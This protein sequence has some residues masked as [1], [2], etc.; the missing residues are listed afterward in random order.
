MPA[1]AP[2]LLSLALVAA[3]GPTASALGPAAAVSRRSAVCGALSSALIASRPLP[4]PAAPPGREGILMPP[5]SPIPG[6]GAGAPLRPVV[7]EAAAGEGA[8]WPPP[9]ATR[10]G[11]ERLGAA[12]LSPLSAALSPLAETELYYPAWLEGEWDVRA[13]LLRKVYPYGT[14]YVPSS[15]L[16]EGSPRNRSEGAGNVVSSRSRYVM[17]A[18]GAKGGAGGVIADRRYNALATSRAYR[19]LTPV[20]EV[21]WDPARDPTRLS[22][23]FEAG[24][25]GEDMRPLGAR[26]AEVYITA[27][28]R[29]EGGDGSTFAASE[30]MRQV[31]VAT[32]SVVV[33]DTETIT[34]YVR[35]GDDGAVA[36][37][38]IA[39]YLTPNPNS[40]EGILWQQ[41][42]GRAVAFFDYGIEM[43]RAPPPTSQT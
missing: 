27:R 3:T 1:A 5:Q 9:P 32:G 41:V 40:R 14:E 22:L 12:D 4:A 26:R 17:G 24:P 31:T 35:R 30:R 11:R 13:T 7:V 28:R 19:Q 37:Q 29:E 43:R 25:L 42:G 8:P 18:G 33:S 20:E 21:A 16:V 2:V 10:L 38:R 39:V 23:S 15:S 36:A 6:I 34:E